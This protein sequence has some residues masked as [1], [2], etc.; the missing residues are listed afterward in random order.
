LSANGARVLLD[1][2]LYQGR[3]EETWRRN[4]EF[5]FRAEGID[6]LVQSHA[7]I[8]HSGKLP[9]LVREGF[10]GAVHA[11]HGTRDLCEVLLRDSAHIQI[12]DAEE[13]NR[14]REREQT[15]RLRRTPVAIPE[16]DEP[17]CM[18]RAALPER[19]V[20]P[21]YVEADV[22]K[23]LRL[24]ESHR[25]QEWFD[26]AQGIRV[27]FH[28]AGHILGSAWIEAQITEGTRV[29]RLVFTGDYGRPGQPVLRDPEPLCEAD[30]FIS[31]STYG[32]RSHPAFEDTERKLGDAVERLARRGRGRLL[33]PVFAVGRAQNLLYTLAKI[34]RTRDVGSVAVVVDSPL[35]SEATEIV[36]RHPEYFDEETASEFAKLKAG[37]LLGKR[38]TFTA[39]VDESKGLNRDQR[40]L[41]ILSASGMLESGR[42]V[43]HVA[44][45]VSSED[46]EILIVGYQARSTL[47]RKLMDGVRE[48][49]M[50][51][52]RFAVRATI[53]PLMGFSAHADREGLLAALTPHSARAKALF[54]VHGENDQR[55]PLARTLGERGFARVE[56]PDDPRPFSF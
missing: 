26:V 30:V 49:N 5:A 44:W 46:C 24:F 36:V 50:L 53:T 2:G 20:Q 47:G 40:P 31:E 54:L 55:D 34:F 8:D 9:L 48:V 56:T 32:D 4:R 28:D 3:R 16:P 10:R 41:V 33:I 1:C 27:R 29:S 45:N 21:L 19:Q 43:H 22:D 15:R 17:P 37:S 42:I 13:L 51:G 38:L 11:T 14:M 7:H 39:S 18:G 6:A 52:R 25:Y 12:V 23:A 35:A